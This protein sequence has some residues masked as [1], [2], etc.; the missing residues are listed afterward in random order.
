MPE[1]SRR[2]ALQ[3]VAGGTLG[4]IAGCLDKLGLSPSPDL[5]LAA[6]AV[7]PQTRADARNTGT[8]EVATL[9][10]GPPERD[11]RF[12]VEASLGAGLA[13][14]SYGVVVG[15]GTLYTAVIR[16]PTEPPSASGE[17]ATA[18]PSTNATPEP[19]PPRM[20]EVYAVDAASGDLAWRRDVELGPHTATSSRAISLSESGLHLGVQT[21]SSTE[22]ELEPTVITLARDDGSVRSREG[23]LF[24]E[25]TVGDGRLYGL[26]TD[27]DGEDV[28]YLG[29]DPDSGGVRWRASPAEGWFPG[30]WLTVDSDHLI[31]STFSADGETRRLVAWSLDDE[32][33]A[34]RSGPLPESG[35]RVPH[36]VGSGTVVAVGERGVD[37]SGG[38]TVVGLDAA[39]GSRVFEHGTDDA[40]PFAP[41]IVDDTALVGTFVGLLP[42]GGADRETSRLYAIDLHDGTVR[43]DTDL[44]A[45]AYGSPVSDGQRVLVPGMPALVVDPDDGTTVWEAATPTPTDATD[46]TAGGT[47][48]TEATR[49]D[50]LSGARGLLPGAGWVFA[51]YSMVGSGP[52]PIDG[53]RGG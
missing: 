11:W 43:Y 47:T 18:T 33:R 46:A 7:W 38:G 37:E 15:N 28:A 41:V 50:S 35:G 24:A 5:A 2:R 8:S 23:P 1:L 26:G 19:R 27:P 10:T 36:A 3:A 6:Q 53:Y 17:T 52:A 45:P 48:A 39:D 30:R 49:S 51:Q 21:A 4:T 22:D 40:L 34:W 29:V 9:P 20:L 32:S 16:S 12:E 44:G 13:D 25:F 31:G 14:G 42:P